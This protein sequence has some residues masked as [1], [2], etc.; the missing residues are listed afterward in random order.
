MSL[1]E[2]FK[3]PHDMLKNIGVIVGAKP[4]PAMT[5][6]HELCLKDEEF[7]FTEEKSKNISASPDNME[8]TEESFLRGILD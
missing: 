7:L 4:D 8:S 3:K 6:L 1:H 5:I 2:R